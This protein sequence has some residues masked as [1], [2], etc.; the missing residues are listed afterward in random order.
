MKP[1]I[2]PIGTDDGQFHGGNQ[3][4]GTKGTIVTPDWLNDIQGATRSVQQE[5]IAVLTAAGLVPAEE[6]AGQLLSAL[7]SLFTGTGSFGTTGYI[8]LP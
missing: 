5:I 3:L 1:L 8:R 4:T 6:T 2:D 7:Q